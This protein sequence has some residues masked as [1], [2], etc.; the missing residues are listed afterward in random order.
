M[1]QSTNT[2]INQTPKTA[3]QDD[4]R[5]YEMNF[6]EGGRLGMIHRRGY[7]TEEGGGSMHEDKVEPREA[8]T[9]QRIENA[10]D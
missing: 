9:D 5:K 4:E 6:Q 8:K 3:N 1:Q 10:R 7:G 2:T